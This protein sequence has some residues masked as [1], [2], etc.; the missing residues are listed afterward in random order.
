MVRRGSQEIDGNE[1]VSEF[2]IR[3]AKITNFAIGCGIAVGVLF[4][5]QYEGFIESSVVIAVLLVISFLLAAFVGFRWWRCPSCE[6]H[7]GK[8]YF[9]LNHPKY[10]P[11]CGV[12]LI[13]S[14]NGDLP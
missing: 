2:S 14:K 8:L 9:G 5:F 11:K 6:G 12:K 3:R 10:C 4:L 13:D 7:L 1:I